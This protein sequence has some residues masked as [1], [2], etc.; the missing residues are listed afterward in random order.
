MSYLSEFLKNKSVG[1]VS[2]SSKSL[3]KYL[4][5][6]L[7]YSNATVIVERGGGQGVFTYEILKLINPACKLLV[8]E[9][10]EAYCKKLKY[11]IQDD[12]AVIIN[13][14]AEKIGDYLEKHNFEKADHIISS[15]PLSM[16][17]LELKEDILKNTTYF[18]S[19]RGQF[20][21]FQYLPFDYKRLKKHFREVKMNFSIRNL[22]PVFIYR[23]S[24]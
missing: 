16:F 13:D 23:C 2:S 9:T 21:Q 20:L 18:L 6:N 3:G 17:S 24:L 15:L 22:P 19:D 14:S 4:F 7:D 12:R 1:A 8:F 10:N 5:G 11:T